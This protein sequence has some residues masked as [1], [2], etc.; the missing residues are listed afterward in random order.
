MQ[1]GSPWPNAPSTLVDLRARVRMCRTRPRARVL[2]SNH[3]IRSLLTKQH[4]CSILGSRMNRGHGGQSHRIPFS[5]SSSCSRRC[6]CCCCSLAGAGQS[7]R[8]ACSGPRFLSGSRSTLTFI[9]SNRQS[10]KSVLFERST[11]AATPSKRAP[12]ASARPGAHTWRRTHDPSPAPGSA[13]SSAVRFSGWAWFHISAT[14]CTTGTS[15]FT[16][17]LED[18]GALS[19]CSSTRVVSNSLGLRSWPPCSDPPPGA[20]P[21]SLAVDVPRCASDP[22][23]LHRRRP[24][25]TTSARHTICSHIARRSRPRPQLAGARGR[26]T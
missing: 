14:S 3:S 7:R 18:Q 19:S 5:S 1:H 20:A 11:G 16:T 13:T 8:R 21:R 24:Q 10:S 26:A 6:S 2:R 25:C 17:R 15:T 12:L 4:D 9:H 22:A 23:A